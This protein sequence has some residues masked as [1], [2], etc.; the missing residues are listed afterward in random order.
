MSKLKHCSN[1]HQNVQPALSSRQGAGCGAFLMC[2]VMGLCMM[3]VD[4]ESKVMAFL[5]VGWWMA[6]LMMLIWFGR[7]KWVCP[8]CRDGKMGKAL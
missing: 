3:F 2:L 1:C 5:V 8:I 7:S 4:V 6:G